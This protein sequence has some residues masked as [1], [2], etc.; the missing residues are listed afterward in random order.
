MLTDMKR[1]PHAHSIPLTCAPTDMHTCVCPRPG[2]HAQ[3]C[4]CTSSPIRT[5]P[6][7]NAATHVHEMSVQQRAQT[8]TCCFPEHACT[9]HT[10]S[11][12]HT[13]TLILPNTCTWCAVQCRHTRAWPPHMSTYMC[14]QARARTRTH[15]CSHCR[16]CPPGQ[17]LAEHPG[18]TAPFPTAEAPRGT[19]G[20]A[21]R[22]L[23]KAAFN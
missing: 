4:T 16:C 2:T 11:S 5:H 6:T 20:S 18:A 7:C 12:A 3:G 19:P 1:H 15:P 13:H 21:G 9:L 14:A 8:H 22:L 17:A 23:I 10:L